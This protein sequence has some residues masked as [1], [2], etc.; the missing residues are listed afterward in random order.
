MQGYLTLLQVSSSVA[1]LCF[2]IVDTGLRPL[3][4][5]VNNGLDGFQPLSCVFRI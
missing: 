5:I 2:P 1:P 3:L 4:G